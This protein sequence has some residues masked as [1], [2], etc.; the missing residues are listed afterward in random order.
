MKR[1]QN[2]NVGTLDS[3]K[4]I[5]KNVSCV[6]KAGEI[7][8]I[9]GPSGAG[10]STLLELL[11]GRI[12]PSSLPDSILVN[13]QPMEVSSFRRISG[14]IAQSDAL[15]P[16]LTVRETLTFSAMLRLP[17]TVSCEEKR[18]M[19]EDL[20]F[21]LRLTHVADTRVGND[22]VRGV[23]GGERRRVSIGV[24]VIHDPAVLLLDEPT[25]GLDS[26]SALH[27]IEMLHS[28][29]KTRFRTIIL[30]I[31]QPGYR[32]IQQINSFLLLSSGSVVHHGSLRVLHYWLIQAGHHVP[33]Q[34]NVLEYAIDAISSG[35]DLQAD[36]EHN[37]ILHQAGRFD[38]LHPNSSGLIMSSF[39]SR[40]HSLP[41][42]FKPAFAN[43]S[44]REILILSQ[45]FSRNIFRTHELF[46]ARTIQALVGGFALGTIYINA[47]LNQA[48]LA[49]R[50][51]FFA[52]TLTYL[53]SSTVEALPIFLQERHVLIP[54]TSRGAYRISSYLVANLLVFMPFLLL[55]AMVFSLPVYWLIGLSNKAG[56]FAF[57][58][59]V[60]WLVLLMANSFVA[61]FSALAPDYIMGN[62]LISGCMGA[63]FLFSGYFISE[64]NMPSYWRFMHYISLFK[65]PLDALLINEYST[66]DGKC[67]GPEIPPAGQCTLTGHDVLQQLGLKVER[68][69][70][71]VAIM[72]AFI[73][74][75]RL[76]CYTV[77]RFKVCKRRR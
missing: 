56:A 72:L 43:T 36:A 21:E 18:K 2:V 67:F 49:K 52:F 76:L 13:R 17:T 14:F 54:E 4:F 33:P 6:G 26:A 31:H 75:Y 39:T 60:M 58:V 27:V 62:S 23:S 1:D 22:E 68:K 64:E 50:L 70:P 40:A 45:R 48:G 29:A 61:F 65:Y 30:S 34:V 20:L 51:G 12:R 19:V 7:L 53:L 55:I 46:T 25:S 3:S 24:D 73:C 63:F 8:A 74:C 66:L 71:N 10:K 44:V 11:A 59:L 15:F 41:L 9:A 69:W 5:L 37:C 35:L 28:M 38:L 57:F 47:G 77:L 32:I 42:E 16:L